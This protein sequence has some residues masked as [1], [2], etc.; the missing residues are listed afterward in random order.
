MTAPDWREELGATIGY[1]EAYI[2]RKIEIAKLDAAEKAAKTGAS[3]AT[4]LIL[5]CTRYRSR[6][7]QTRN[8]SRC[9]SSGYSGSGKIDYGDRRKSGERYN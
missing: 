4:G 5:L 3:L 2:E 6:A 1:T 8:R 9:C 7:S